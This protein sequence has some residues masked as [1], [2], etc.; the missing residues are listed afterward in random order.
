LS[1]LYAA[2][3]STYRKISKDAIDAGQRDNAEMKNAN[4]LHTESLERAWRSIAIDRQDFL[5]RCQGLLIPFNHSRSHCTLSLVFG[6][7]R[8]ITVFDSQTCKNRPEVGYAETLLATG[9]KDLYVRMD[10]KTAT[11]FD[12]RQQNATNRSVFLCAKAMAVFLDMKA[13]NFVDRQDKAT[14]EGIR[15]YIA[16]CLQ[17]VRGI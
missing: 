8:K 14:L 1:G 11:A 2:A 5:D 6:V 13:P 17:P 16:A 7:E 15:Q 3:L 9:L 12:P 4:R 10:W